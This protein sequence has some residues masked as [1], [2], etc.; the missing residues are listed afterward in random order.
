MQFPGEN[1]LGQGNKAYVKLR[2]RIYV[3]VL[4]GNCGIEDLKPNTLLDQQMMERLLMRMKIVI[5]EFFRRWQ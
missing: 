1:I 2:E 4:S 5:I 3:T